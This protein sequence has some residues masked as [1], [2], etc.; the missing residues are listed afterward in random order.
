VNQV[1]QI[2]DSVKGRGRAGRAIFLLDQCGY[3][4]VPFVTIRKILGSLENAEVILT[5]AT[6]FLIDYLSTNEQSQLTLQ[7]TGIDLPSKSIATAKEERAW[8]RVI[9]F[10]LHQQIPEKTGAKYYT[11]FFIRSSD[12][13]RDFW[14]IHLSGHFRARD[15]MVGLHWQES[16]AF[17]HFGR[18]GLR[19]L[20]YDPAYDAEWT[21]Q[22]MLPGYYFDETARTSSQ[23]E[24][25]EQLP[26]NI[27]DFK[28]GIEFNQL[29]AN[30]TNETPVTAEIMMDVI[31]DLAKEGVVTIRK[32]DGS[33][34]VRGIKHGTDIILPNRQKRLFIHGQ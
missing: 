7:K 18:S 21:K 30:L 14:L 19:M 32:K 22:K 13:H 5:F 8:R 17:A 29:F 23:E 3:S 34:R 31:S 25:L 16:T 20:G 11:P 10:A 15:V 33:T 27:H 4:D 1:P 24:L 9:Q 26:R 12:S 6:D 28:K 2:I